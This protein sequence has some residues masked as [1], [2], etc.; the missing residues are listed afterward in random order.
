M[1]ELFSTLSSVH[2]DW[3]L[4]IVGSGDDSENKN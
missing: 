3:K 1:K 4:H 2:G